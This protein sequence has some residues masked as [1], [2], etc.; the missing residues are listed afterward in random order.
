MKTA[1]LIFVIFAGAVKA[2][3]PAGATDL[4][5]SFV[6]PASENLKIKDT[7]AKST[8]TLHQN[9]FDTPV[10]E[11][12]IHGGN[13]TYSSTGI[14]SQSIRAMVGNVR[15]YYSGPDFSDSPSTPINSIPKF[16]AT[17]KSVSL[18]IQK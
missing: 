5:P 18:K 14:G 3:L 1:A 9:S 2:E 7:G 17:L 12:P 8:V 6:S 4:A 11:Q 13:E 16:D 10:I 15:L